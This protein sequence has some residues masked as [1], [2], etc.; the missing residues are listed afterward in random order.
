VTDGNT[1]FSGRPVTIRPRRRFR[2]GTRE[3]LRTVHPASVATSLL[4]AALAFVGIVVILP[5]VA[6]LPRSISHHPGAGPSRR[7][8]RDHGDL[9]RRAVDG[10]SAD[11]RH[12]PD[13]VQS[14]SARRRSSSIRPQ[15]HID[16]AAQ[17]VQG[18]SPPR[19][20]LALTLTTPRPTA[21]SIGRFPILIL[22]VNSDTLPLTTVDD[23]ADNSWP[24]DVADHGVAQW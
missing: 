8:R 7:Q 19:Q 11:R 14:T 13:D 1:S 6:P 24:A 12:H 2:R 20:D 22:A 4:M 9:G 15:P 17:D 18:R 21:R 16:G 23:Y 5:A 3:H 10:N